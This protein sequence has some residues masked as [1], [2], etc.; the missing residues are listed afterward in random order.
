MPYPFPTVC[1]CNIQPLLITNVIFNPYCLLMQCQ[2]IL[3]TNNIPYCLLMQYPTLTI[4]FI[5]CSLMPHASRAT[6]SEGG[7]FFAPGSPVMSPATL[8]NSPGMGGTPNINVEDTQ[9]GQA[10]TL[11][12]VCTGN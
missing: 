8:R 2:P 12:L 1:Q 9:T 3:L 5:Y 10:V 7:M 4:Y 6:Q 11:L